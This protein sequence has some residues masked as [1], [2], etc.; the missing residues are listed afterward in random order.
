VKPFVSIVVPL[1]NE[2]SF[3]ERLT[4]SLLEQDYPRDRYEIL[5]ADG[6]STDRTLEI[7]RRVDADARVR[8]LANPRRTAPA[9]MNVLIAA[10]RGEIVTRVD[11]HSRIASDYLRRVVDVMEETGEAVVGGPVLLEADTPFRRALVEALVSAS[12][13]G[14]FPIGPSG[15]GRTSS[16]CR[17]A[18]S[19][20]TSSTRPDPGTSRSRSSRTST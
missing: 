8:V 7:L 19:G 16:R 18:P 9:A 10:A 14:R 1:L 2:E 17:P 15:P 11:G 13:W 20:S 3:I 12:G 4:R 6:G 5:M